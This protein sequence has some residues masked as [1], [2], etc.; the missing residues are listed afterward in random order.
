MKY[1]FV[2][3][4]G[5]LVDDSI[6]ILSIVTLNDNFDLLYDTIIGQFQ[7][8]IEISSFFVHLSSLDEIT[9]RHFS[10]RL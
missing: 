10:L 5:F 4:A 9:T 6:T 7:L 1:E 3:V 2:I 8:Q